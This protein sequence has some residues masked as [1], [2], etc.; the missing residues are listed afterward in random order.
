LQDCLDCLDWVFRT[1]VD[2]KVADVIFL[3]DLFHDRQKID[4]LT[5]QKTFETFRKYLENAAIPP[6][7]VWILLGNHD[8]WH[9]QKWDVSS[10]HPLGAIEG[11]TVIDR[12]D[13]FF[14]GGHPIAFLPY[15]HD[16]I[17]DLESLENKWKKVSNHITYRKHP[18]ILC[19]HLAIDGALWNTK[20]QTFSD[21]IVEHDGDM[22]KIDPSLFDNWEQVFL[23]HYH[24]SQE[25]NDFIEYVGS[26]LQLSFGE[27]GQK[28]H[29][30]I[31]DLDTGEKE[32]I[33]NQFS[34]KHYI[35]TEDK[36]TQHDLKNQFVRISVE[37]I[38]ASGMIEVQKELVKKGVRTV[39]IQQAPRIDEHVV[40]DAKSILYKQEEMLDQYL[41]QVD[42]EGLN[43]KK[44]LAVGRKICHGGQE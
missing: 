5:Y 11:V 13:F 3:G 16:P 14:I 38:S 28:K 37:D 21:V 12:P 30:L 32:Y 42:L 6:Y 27:T 10:C 24:A 8:L 35:L 39:Q 4:V 26:P 20:H 9:F 22:V 44:L 34:P 23:G 18:K 41:N 2:Q 40:L 17:K 7:R 25:L 36:L 29:I 1:A 43:K 15:T 19:G 31:Y 33:E